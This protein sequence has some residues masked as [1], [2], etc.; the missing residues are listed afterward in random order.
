MKT[1]TK[2]SLLAGCLILAGAITFVSCKK[3]SNPTTPKS[4]NTSGTAD[5]NTADNTSKDLNNIGA[6]A[7]GSGTLTT[8]KLSAGQGNGGVI[9]P[10]SGSVVIFVDS[11]PNK[12]LTVTFS[13]F[14]GYDGHTRNGTIKYNWSGST[15]SSPY[16][17]EKNGFDVIISSPSNDYYVDGNHVVINQKEVK[18]IGVDANGCYNWTD[19]ANINIVK[20]NNG[21]TISWTHNGNMILVNTNAITYNGVN[22]NG[23]YP[24]S[25]G[26]ID[27]LHA[28]IGFTGTVTGTTASGDA[29]TATIT[30]RVDYNMNCSPISGTLWQYFHPPVA[31]ALDYVQ[32]GVTYNINYGSQTCDDTYVV[33]VGT[34]S[35]SLS[36]I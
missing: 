28:I 6:E 17:F 3:T 18:N 13:N 11:I 35:V 2:L 4:Y 25:G 21:G 10:M 1:Q 5:N 36:F 16:Y 34:W 27:W 7:I 24:T 9:S 20:A 29:Y 14:V 15:C 32:G 33:T 19:V 12:W 23:V 8:Y 31:G 26:F 30:T 22:V